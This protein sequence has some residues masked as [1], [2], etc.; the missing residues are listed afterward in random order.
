MSHVLQKLGVQERWKKRKF[1][2]I[3]FL[4]HILNHF[5]RPP[6]EDVDLALGRIGRSFGYLGCMAAANDKQFSI[7]SELLKSIG[8]AE[9]TH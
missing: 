7:I 2:K 6:T 8:C 3:P 5:E 9:K 1:C 4:N